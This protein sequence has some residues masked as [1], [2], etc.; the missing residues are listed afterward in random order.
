MSTQIRYIA[1]VLTDIRSLLRL[2][3]RLQLENNMMIRNATEHGEGDEW[4]RE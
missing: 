1:K 4:K 2:L 3:V